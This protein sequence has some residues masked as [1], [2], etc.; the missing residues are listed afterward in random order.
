MNRGSVFTTYPENYDKNYNDGESLRVVK[1]R[2]LYLEDGRRG[3]TSGVVVFVNDKVTLALTEDHA[4]RLADG[5]AD[6][7]ESEAA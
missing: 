1:A 5:I 3:T 4:L 2:M 6:V 7:L